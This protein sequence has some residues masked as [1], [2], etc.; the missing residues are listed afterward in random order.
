MLVAFPNKLTN[1]GL[2]RAIMMIGYNEQ[3]NGRVYS[4]CLLHGSAGKQHY[5]HMCE[6]ETKIHQQLKMI[7]VQFIR[8]NTKKSDKPH[9]IT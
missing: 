1:E 9:N 2:Y 5:Q 7:M 6:Y 8:V 4:F 3:K